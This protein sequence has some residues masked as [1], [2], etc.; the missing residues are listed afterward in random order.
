M[1]VKNHYPYQS[2]RK[3]KELKINSCNNKG[4][5]NLHAVK[6]SIQLNQQMFLPLKPFMQCTVKELITNKTKKI[7][8]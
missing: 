7:W 8:N 6:I 1:M 4:L 5:K 2:N 3:Q